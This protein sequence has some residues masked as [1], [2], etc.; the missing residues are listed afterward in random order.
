MHPRIDSI[1][2][3]NF[4]FHLLGSSHSTGHI[5]FDSEDESI[6]GQEH[7]CLVNNITADFNATRPYPITT[8]SEENDQTNTKKAVEQ[9]VAV[10]LC[11]DDQCKNGLPG[12]TVSLYLRLQSESDQ[13]SSHTPPPHHPH[14]HGGWEGEE[15][16]QKTD[17][18]MKDEPPDVQSSN[19][20][21]EREKKG[22][23]WG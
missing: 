8:E 13:V 21:V 18:R 23:W 9:K 5:R 2:E 12:P 11:L 4:S 14:P 7:V 1:C 22:G 3:L 6:E 10:R 15:G 19:D 17:E 20:E 16:Y